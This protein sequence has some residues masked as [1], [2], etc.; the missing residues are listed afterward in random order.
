M[1]HI[2]TRSSAPNSDLLNSRALQ[3]WENVTEDYDKIYKHGETIVGSPELAQQLFTRLATESSRSIIIGG[4]LGDEG[5]GRLVDNEI[6][7]MLQL[8]KAKRV[9]VIRYQG[10]NNA[11]HTIQKEIEEDGVKREVKLALHVV[12]SGVM[13]PEAVG[14]IDSGVVVNPEDLRTE[15]GYVEAEPSIGD[16]R[17]KLYV[18]ENAIL[19]TDLERVMEWANTLLTHN[20]SGGTSRGIGPS[21]AGHYDRTG[22]KI[23]DFMSDAWKDTLGKKY[24]QLSR[25]LTAVHGRDLATVEVPDFA[26]TVKEGKAQK[27]TVGTK[28][29]FIDRLSDARSWLESRNMVRETWTIHEE[30]LRDVQKGVVFEGAQAVGLHAWL[31][32][33]PDVTASNTTAHGITEGTQGFWTIDQTQKRMA[34]IKHNPSSVGARHMPTHIDLPR[35]TN[36]LPPD[37]TSEQ[38]Y[39][40]WVRDVANERGTTTGRWRDMN[41]LDLAAL[42]FNLKVGGVNSLAITHLDVAKADQP[43]RVATHYKDSNGND[44]GY[45]PDLRYL[46]TLTA[47]YVELPGWDGE[48]AQNATTFDSLPENAKKYL[49][50]IQARTGVPIVAATTGPKR[51]NFLEFPG[52]NPA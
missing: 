24:D 42:S 52:N 21:Y 43:I 14:I 45:R 17:D 46:N 40:A 25:M 32:T 28:D 13:Y 31:G 50:F 9:N 33:Y 20:A 27:R 35:N 49:A 22:L 41:H 29:E 6:D 2:E 19:N 1:P 15:V 8:R 7:S 12:P 36:D 26:A 23:H 44:V 16:I 37:A 48:A 38:K 11:G 10:G 3:P 5:K 47:Q 34:V 18:S 39:G 51:D 30:T 4:Q